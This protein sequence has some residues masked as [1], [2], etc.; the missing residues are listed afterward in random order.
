MSTTRYVTWSLH[1]KNRSGLRLFLDTFSASDSSSLN[2]GGGVTTGPDVTLTTYGNGNKQDVKARQELR[3]S[4]SVLNSELS[5]NPQT[6]QARL[7]DLLESTL[8]NRRLA[9]TS[10][11]I[12][13]ALVAQIFDGIRDH[14]VTSS[15]LKFNCFSLMPVVDKF[16]ALLRDDLEVAF[17]EDLDSVFDVRQARRALERQKADLEFEL[18]RVERLQQKFSNIQKS[19]SS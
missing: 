10:E 19:L 18:K 17:E 11:E 15:E 4:P 14:F 12:V 16:P 9:P 6:S 3:G 13:N 1:N 5:G 8:W 7:V 2:A